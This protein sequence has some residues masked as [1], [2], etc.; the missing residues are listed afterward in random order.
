M[1]HSSTRRRIS[2]RT[3]VA[4]VALLSVAVPAG[5]S[6]IIQNF[7]VAKVAAAP[8]CFVKVAGSD[9]LVTA[10][11]SSAALASTGPYVKVDT[12]PTLLANGVNLINETIDI[13]GFA[14][15]RTK[16]TDV[17]RYQNNCAVPMTVRLVAEADPAGNAVTSA[18]W[19]DMYVKAYL[20]TIAAP[21]ATTALE[22]SS[23]WSQQFTI[24]GAAAVVATGGAI[25]VAPGT[26]LQGAFVVDVTNTSVAT[27]T[28]HYTATATA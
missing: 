22:T 18:G 17:I 2:R 28:F 15:D 10:Y 21:V 8:A 5:A 4:T 7:I 13:R 11:G 6:V 14:G 26:E 24:D 25:T 27:R 23:N 1:E 9:A 3:A 12:T 19:N 16:Y 20:S